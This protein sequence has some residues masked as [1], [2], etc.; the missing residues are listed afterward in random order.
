[1]PAPTPQT[2]A[3]VNLGSSP[4]NSFAYGDTWGVNGATLIS[5]GGVRSSTLAE[6]NALGAI[7]GAAFGNV[8]GT[9]IFEVEIFQGGV[10]RLAFDADLKMQSTVDGYATNT[11]RVQVNQSPSTFPPPDPP[12]SINYAD[13]ALNRSISGN[14]LVN[15]STSFLSPEFTLE[16]WMSGAS[17]VTFNITQ[18]SIAGATVI[19]EPSSMAIFGLMSVG[20]LVAWRRRRGGERKS[21]EA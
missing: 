14:N 7:S 16:D 11:F 2:S 20:S 21:A 9:S 6:V 15:V 17:N 18:T 1:M 19:P 3:L 13:S 12:P 4:T 10:Y 5:T 8:G